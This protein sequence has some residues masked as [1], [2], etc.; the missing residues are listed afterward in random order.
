[1]PMLYILIG[2]GAAALLAAGVIEILFRQRREQNERARRERVGQISRLLE[3]APSRPIRYV[4]IR[5]P[6]TQ[7]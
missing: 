1:M 5:L 7:K 4:D 6:D 3:S 2:S